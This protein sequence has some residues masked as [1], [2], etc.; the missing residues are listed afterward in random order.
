MEFFESEGGSEFLSGQPLPPPE[1]KTGKRGRGR[2]SLK[3]SE[4]E[5]EPVSIPDDEQLFQ[6][7][8][9]TIGEVAVMFGVNTSLLRHW[10]GEFGFKLRKNRKGD[11]FF[12]PE[13]IKK[14]GLIYD[15][16]RRRK[17]TKEGA[18]YYLIHNKSAEA[19]WATIQHL[20]RLKSFLHELKANL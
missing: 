8:Y 3:E 10:E 11:Q 2:K 19:R 17:F 16:L 4:G 5:A 15:L 13:D 12:K 6:K 1:P 7:Q 9:Y 14:L 20:Q 18:K